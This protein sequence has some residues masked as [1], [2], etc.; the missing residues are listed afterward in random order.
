MGNEVLHR[1]KEDRIILHTKKRRKIDWIGCILC[2]KCP[3]KSIIK[4]KR[5]KIK[6]TGKRERR[7]KE[8]LDDLKETRRYGNCK[9]KHPIAMCGE[10]AVEGEMDLL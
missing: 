5:R 6:V 4:G 1:V 2:R 10:L 8:L 7:R 9:R 3:L